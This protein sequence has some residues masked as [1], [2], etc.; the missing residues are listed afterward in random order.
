MFP[1]AIHR[2][3]CSPRGG[4]LACLLAV[5]TAAG[6]PSDGAAVGEEKP[7]ASTRVG[8]ASVEEA[9]V[10]PV[11]EAHFQA[12]IENSPFL[13]SLDLSDS[14][15]LTG[16]ARIEGDLYVTLFRTDTKETQ[17][18]TDAAN[19]QGWRLVGVEGDQSKLESMTARIAMSGGEVFTVR[20]DER[21]LKPGEIRTASRPGSSS[22]SGQSSDR[23]RRDYRE[24]VSGDG[25]RGPPP[26]D[27][28]EKMSKLDEGTRNRLIDEIARIRE[29]GVS[30]EERQVIFRRMVERAAAATDS[31]RR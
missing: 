17:V 23:P 29:R 21:Q 24:G 10:T 22:G 5:A 2:F 30:S 26:K 3:P 27:L 16:V 14:V 7:E 18:V 12:L 8:A 31:R 9:V 1:F 28:V 15:I 20:F 6:V 4:R 19:P 25:F 13:R 11:S